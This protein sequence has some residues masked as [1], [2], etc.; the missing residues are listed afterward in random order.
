[1]VT[2]CSSY[3]YNRWC[4]YYNWLHAVPP[5]CLHVCKRQFHFH[6]LTIAP[7]IKPCACVLHFSVRCDCLQR[8]ASAE[9]TLQ[10]PVPVP[11]DV[12]DLVCRASG[13]FV[14]IVVL[15]RHVRDATLDELT[16]TLLTL[17]DH[18]HYHVKCFKVN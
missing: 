5:S 15:P 16:W 2:A 11:E 18:V 6:D 14:S 13:G 10:A 9:A 1:M 8:N 3:Y 4:T 17:Q 7:T 12:R